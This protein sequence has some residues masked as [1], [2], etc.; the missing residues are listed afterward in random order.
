MRPFTGVYQSQVGICLAIGNPHCE[1]V[2][3]MV[4]SLVFVGLFLSKHRSLFLL[5]LDGLSISLY[6]RLSYMGEGLRLITNLDGNRLGLVQKN[7]PSWACQDTIRYIGIELSACLSVNE[8]NTST[9][10]DTKILRLEYHQIV[11]GLYQAINL[12]SRMS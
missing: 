2:R 1:C 7:Y 3:S 5:S 12:S 8:P 10:T 9:E 11:G 4:F 6:G